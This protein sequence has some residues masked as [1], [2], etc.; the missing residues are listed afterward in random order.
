M[1]YNDIYVMEAFHS[2]AAF[3]FM[4]SDPAVDG[5]FKLNNSF[6]KIFIPLVRCTKA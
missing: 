4:L 5:Q 3:Q 1:L 6:L 2:A